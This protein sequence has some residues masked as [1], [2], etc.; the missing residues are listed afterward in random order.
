MN[1]ATS[2]EAEEYINFNGDQRRLLNTRRGQFRPRV[3]AFPSTAMILSGNAHNRRRRPA[4]A[5]CN[6]ISLLPEA[7]FQP[8]NDRVNMWPYLSS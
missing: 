5:A 3:S 6:Q 8:L 7:D 1:A 4:F 2:R